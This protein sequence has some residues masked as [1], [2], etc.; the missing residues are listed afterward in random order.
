MCTHNVAVVHSKDCL[1]AQ[2]SLFAG[3]SAELSPH[4]TPSGNQRTAGQCFA[5][6]I[7]NLD[8]HKYALCP[9]S[10]NCVA[11][12]DR[13]V[14]AQLTNDHIHRT[15]RRFKAARTLQ[16]QAR[17]YANRL[18]Y[19]ELQRRRRQAAKQLQRVYRK[20]LRVLNTAAL[21]IQS[22]VRSA[23]AQAQASQMRKRLTAA[24]VLQKIFRGCI[25][26]VSRQ[27]ER[28]ARMMQR[29]VRSALI[30]V[31]ARRQ[32]AARVL[33]RSQR[34]MRKARLEKEVCRYDHLR[35]L[36]NHQYL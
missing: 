2:V 17:S 11:L 22:R 25:V 26:R 29:A 23:K 9:T 1:C 33:Q 30:R 24:Q 13:Q 36:L 20:R 6:N 32:T 19:K 18:R 14:T 21:I 34:R 8:C 5:P 31:R 12:K 27:R 3:D 35:V 28:S 16:A 15:Q 4:Q 10:S 7:P